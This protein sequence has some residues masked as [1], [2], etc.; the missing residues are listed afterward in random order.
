MKKSVGKLTVF[1]SSTVYGVE[2]LLDRVYTL[3]TSFGYEVW[4]SHKGTVPV[5]SD[6]TAFENC[7]AAVEACDLFLGIITPHYGSGK[8]PDKPDGPSITHLEMRRVLE[9]P[10]KP[11]WVLAHDHVV[12]ARSLLKNLGFDGAEGRKKLKLR[13]S[14]ILDDLR[15][16]DLYE[17][18]TLDAKNVPLAERRGNWAQK[19]RSDEDG[20]LFVT[21]Q[22]F[23]YQDVEEFLREQFGAVGKPTGKEGGT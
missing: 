6:R 12:F 5:R 4:M 11:R 20:A 2:E 9:F 17:E 19:F 18:A 1:V 7:L 22:F 21:A 8:D 10:N 14:P 16:L 23:R 15:V 3:L 13:K